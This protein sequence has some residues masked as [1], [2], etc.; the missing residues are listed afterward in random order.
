MALEHMQAS[1]IK[2]TPKPAATGKDNIISL[3]AVLA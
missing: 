1:R 3:D 2:N